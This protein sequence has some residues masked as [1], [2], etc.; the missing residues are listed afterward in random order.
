MSEPN[1]LNIPAR[2]AP[3]LRDLRRM[4]F[5]VV[6]RSPDA[7]A[8]LVDQEES[9]EEDAQGDET[10]LTSEQACEI[11]GVVKGSF[12]RGVHS[13]KYP[14]PVERWRKGDIM[15]VVADKGEQSDGAD[16]T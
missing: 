12:T 7:A 1:T 13:G 4:G 9:T 5:D 11:I 14:K 6:P 10:L 8:P 16:N 2:Y 15:A 3:T